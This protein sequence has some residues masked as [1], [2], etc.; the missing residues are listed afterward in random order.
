MRK[1][2][3]T[4]VFA[5]GFAVASAIA[6]P[7]LA[8]DLAP[9]LQSFGASNAISAYQLSATGVT[10]YALQPTVAAALDHS[11]ARL[12]DA[13][14]GAPLMSSFATSTVLSPNLALDAGAGLDIASRF[15]NYAAAAPAS[16]FLSAVSAPFLN[17]ANGGRYSGVTFVPTSD[18]RV[19][20][21]TSI[22]SERLDSF[23]FGPAAPTGNLGVLYDASQTRSLLAGLSWDISDLLGLDLTGISSDRSGVPLGIANA[24]LIA[25]KA[26]TQALG[27]AGHLTIGQG[28]VTTASFSEG[29]T[30]LEQ[31]PGLNTNL[32]EQSYSIAIAKHGL[33]GDDTLGLSF[34]RPA[35][36]MA[37]GLATLMGSGD[38]PPLVVAQVP[39]LVPGR[40]AAENDIQLGYVTNFLNGAVALQTNAA[41]QTNFQGQPGAT[42]VSLLSRAKIKF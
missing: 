20:L 18:V 10:G 5:A 31:R 2:V 34:S 15:T 3:H 21:G 22:N 37:G 17:L 33:F 19:R 26:S 40:S 24:S 7:V 28:W 6:M 29:L 12:A 25:P 32:R 1:L 36:S 13:A 27:V 38:L 30:Q 4:A 35:P 11:G 8:A 16:P 42:S 9:S 23:H 41:Y 39:S 14:Y